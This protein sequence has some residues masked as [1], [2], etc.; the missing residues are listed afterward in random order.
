MEEFPMQTVSPV[1]K[2]AVPVVA[3]V[4]I[5]GGVTVYAVHEHHAA[6]IA[7][8][9]KPAGDGGTDVDARPVERSE[10]QVNAMAAQAQ[11]PATAPRTGPRRRSRSRTAEPNRKP[12]A[13]RRALEARCRRSWTQQGK[14]IE[15][16][17]GDLTSTTHAADGLD[18]A[19]P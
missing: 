15:Q 3:A 16:T 2:F 9:P 7:G 18:C 5:L 14:E 4:A 19:H 8:G 6:Q 12:A 17:R 1:V 11:A 10:R 13:R